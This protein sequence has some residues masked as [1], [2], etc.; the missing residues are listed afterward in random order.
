MQVATGWALIRFATSREHGELLTMIID[1][2]N[3]TQPM[4][5]AR[6]VRLLISDD[7]WRY[8]HAVAITFPKNG[9]FIVQLSLQREDEFYS[10][11]TGYRFEMMG[12]PVTTILAADQCFR[13]WT[14]VPLPEHPDL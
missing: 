5:L 6:S 2:L 1:S 4:S 13:G 7:P 14:L 8:E 10:L 3:Q 9:H 12:A 11:V